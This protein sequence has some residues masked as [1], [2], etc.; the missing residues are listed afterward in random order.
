MEWAQ[1]LSRDYLVKIVMNSR[2][3]IETRPGEYKQ[4]LGPAREADF[5]PR[6]G[7]FC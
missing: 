7:D 2:D 4:P 1:R 3:N 6:L 5:L